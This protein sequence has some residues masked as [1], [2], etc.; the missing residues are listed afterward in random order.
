MLLQLHTGRVKEFTDQQPSLVYLVSTVQRVVDAGL[1]WVFSDGHGI[2]RYT[3]WFERIEDLDKV[4]WVAV[5]S[6]I[7]KDTVDDMDRQRKK[8]SEFLVH[9]ACPWAVIGEIGVC[10][11]WA[12]QRVESVLSGFPPMMCRPV[13]IQRAWYY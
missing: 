5:N 10:N 13:H 7:W 3:Q 8:Q 9:E 2:A 1:G 4:D 11:Y 12:L 6:I